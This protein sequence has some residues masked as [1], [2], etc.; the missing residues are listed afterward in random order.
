LHFVV[1]DQSEDVQAV[2]A[3]LEKVPEPE[4]GSALERFG[5]EF[6]NTQPGMLMRTTKRFPEI[7]Q[8]Q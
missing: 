8:R 4:V 3:V 7:V 1:V 2:G 6:A 5:A